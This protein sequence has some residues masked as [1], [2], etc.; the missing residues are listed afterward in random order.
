MPNRLD[1]MLKR[2]LRRGGKKVLLGW[3][4]GLGDIPLGLYAVVERIR[5]IVPDAEITF[6][7]RHNLYDGF[8][9]LAGVK[10]I[11]DPHWK[12]GDPYRIDRDLRKKYD[13]VI[14]NPSP[15]DWVYWQ[16]G[17]LVP[18]LKWNSQY[19]SLYERFDLPPRCIGV[20]VLTETNYG[21][22]RNWPKE[23]W[24]KLFDRLGDRPVLLF[25]FGEEPQFPNR[26]LIDLRGKTTLFELISIIKNRVSTLIL[27]DSGISSMVY[28]LNETFPIRQVTLW[29]DPDHGILKQGVPS[30]NPKLIHRPLVAENQNLATLEVETVFS[31]LEKKVLPILLAGGQG[32][33][34]GVQGPKGLFQ[35]AGKTLFQWFC[36]KL[37]KGSPLAIMTSSINHEETVAYFERNGFFGLEVH[38]FKQEMGPLLDEKKQ[39]T[40]LEGPNGNGS[41]FRSFVNAGLG[42]YFAKREI[43][44]IT[45]SYIDNPLSNPL[46][47]K[48]I[49]NLD[50]IV[51]Q[52][53]ER[54][55]RD[56]SMGVLV[57]K[58]GKFEV[59]EY[60]DFDASQTYK[61]AYSGQ[62]AFDFSF[63]CKMGDVELPI[64]WVQKQIEGKTV[65]KGEHFLFDVFKY[66]KSV[67]PICVERKSHYAP[68]KSPESIEKALK[69]LETV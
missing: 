44:C 30:P 36:D 34:L 52:C 39:P 13:L 17:K 6:V 22:W 41:V 58:E 53:I 33:R 46:D 56:G 28:Y 3:N 4:R 50:E 61:Y 2:L 18:K 51:V 26:N 65:W 24:G 11:I 42:G 16:K 60:T 20:Q 45:V 10:A 29:A 66:A 9:M 31:A 14:E 64:H 54:D 57:E 23:K 55:S 35:I 68:I 63:F 21:Q 38:F 47:S 5:E 8:S 69:I 43:E 62:I 25:G 49:D 40:G 27:P 67:K 12:R 7:T 32:S 48:L 15:T 59:V 37:P 1:W 19:E